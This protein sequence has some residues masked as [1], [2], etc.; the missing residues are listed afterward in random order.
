MKASNRN[1]KSTNANK[2]KREYRVQRD[3]ANGLNTCEHRNLLPNT[4]NP[5]TPLESS[6]L[7][8]KGKST[9]ITKCS[10]SRLS[11][12]FIYIYNSIYII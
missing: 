1:K 11:T 8:K 9:L 3:R 6:L 10:R 5:F 12:S 7:H 2:I 4:I